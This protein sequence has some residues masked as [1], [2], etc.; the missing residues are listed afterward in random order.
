MRFFDMFMA[1]VLSQFITI[2]YSYFTSKYSNVCFIQMNCVQHDA[3]KIY[4]TYA[5]DGEMEDCFL[6]SHETKQ[7]PK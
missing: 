5:V 1:L 3:T 2:R 4:S 6:L 7:S